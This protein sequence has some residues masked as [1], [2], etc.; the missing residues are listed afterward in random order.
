[1]PEIALVLGP[2]LFQDFEVPSAITFGG[3][4]R[5]VTHRLP[6]GTRVIDALGRDDAQIH[7][8]GIFTGADATLRARTLDGLRSAGIPLP[9]TWD[10]FFFTVVIAEFRADYRNGWWIP[11][12]VSCTILQDEA[13]LPL[14]L[15]VSI[16]LATSE[17][18][19]TATD[20]AL[21]A[22]LDISGLQTQFTA[23]GTPVRGTDTFTGLQASL[24]ATQLTVGNA[25]AQD[26]EVVQGTDLGGFDSAQAGVVGLVT[27][28]NAMANL[29]SLS[30]AKAYIGRSAVNLE[31][32]ST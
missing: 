16:A 11:Y 7:F 30:A 1:M 2:I 9:I 6:G 15:P 22:G 17:D 32:T 14:A 3:R 12:C 27:A 19:A 31:N 4:Q 20:Q 29:S 24:S 10:V 21:V 18:I 23:A 8:S 25:M 26:E 28:T 13:V 5:M